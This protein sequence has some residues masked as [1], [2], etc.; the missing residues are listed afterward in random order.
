[1]PLPH[2]SIA[3]NILFGSNATNKDLE[4]VLE[5]T[6]LKGQENKFPHELSGGQQQKWQFQHGNYK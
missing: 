3:S 4:E 2:L 6:K 5:K 1:M